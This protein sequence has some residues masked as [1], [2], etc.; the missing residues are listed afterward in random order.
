VIRI[1]RAAAIF[2]WG[3]T[4]ASSARIPP[5]PRLSARRTKV[6]YL[7]ETTK[8]IDQNTS[9]ITPITFSRVAG[10]L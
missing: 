6:T 2:A 9:D 8:L 4:K 10:M 5:S 1:L 7:R 3:R